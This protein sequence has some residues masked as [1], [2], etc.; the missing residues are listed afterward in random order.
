MFNAHYLRT[1]ITLVETGSFTQTARKLEMTQPGVSQHIRKLEQYFSMPLLARKGKR[2]DLTDAGRQVY[3]YAVRLFSEHEQFKHSLDNLMPDSGEC[4]IASV[5]SFGVL[6]YPFVLGY[7]KNYPR[8]RM[9]YRF[10][11][12]NEAI[13]EVLAKRMDVAIVTDMVRHPD[14]TC[15]PFMEEP[16]VVIVPADFQGGTLAEL[17]GLGFIEHQQAREQIS[18]LFKANFRGEYRGPRQLAVRSQVN[19][20][21]MV[22]DAVARGL[23]F[24]VLPRGV[25]ES[26]PWQQ[27]TR[28]WRLS[29]DVHE[30][31]YL[32]YQDS[33]EL[34]ERYS[35]LLEAYRDWRLGNEMAGADLEA[36][37]ETATTSSI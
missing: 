12:N 3:E 37:G 21:N 1:F 32:V 17:L 27:Q 22:L 29:E 5:A 30:S 8:M 20:I 7:L 10:T 28:E 34:P 18:M 13:G 36:A 35:Y 14:L 16:L 6:F 11:S 9:T 31:L 15:K 4:R 24:T 26:S 19:R 2:F 33:S 25:W 23:G